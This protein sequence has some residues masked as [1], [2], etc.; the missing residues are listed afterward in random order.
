VKRQGAG[1]PEKK[2]IKQGRQ[3]KRSPVLIPPKTGA[4]NKKH[5]GN[6]AS[7]AIM[8]DKIDFSNPSNAGRVN[9]N[10]LACGQTINSW[11]KYPDAPNAALGKAS[12]ADVTS[13]KGVHFC[14]K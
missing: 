1:I 11:L 13:R 4:T 10:R 2:G 7:Y 8:D 6:S 3:E 5:I 14:G 9:E 12:R